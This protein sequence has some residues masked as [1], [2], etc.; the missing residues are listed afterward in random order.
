MVEKKSPV[1][2]SETERLKGILTEN[3]SRLEETHKVLIEQ[4]E[5]L[6]LESDQ[7]GE[8]EMLSLTTHL[9]SRYPTLIDGDYE[10]RVG[11][12][13]TLTKKSGEILERKSRRLANMTPEKVD[14]WKIKSEK[15]REQLMTEMH[16]ENVANIRIMTIQSEERM[17]AF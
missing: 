8:G 16:P 7:E 11:I 10:A 14:L 13:N 6:G 4:L 15:E 3:M 9:A 17:S 2:P 12:L 1:K 5:T